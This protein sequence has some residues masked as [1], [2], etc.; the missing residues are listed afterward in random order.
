MGMQLHGA[1]VLLTGASG[2]FGQALALQLA[3]RGALLVLSG[4][5]QHALDHLAR[6]IQQQG[7]AAPEVLVA[8]LL[9][10]DDVRRLAQRCN[11]PTEPVDV[12]VLNA[13]VNRLGSFARSDGRALS[14]VLAVDLHAPMQLVHQCLPA[15]LR[16]PK[17][18]ILFVNST[19]GRLGHPGYAAYCAAKHGL[20]GLAEALR[21]ELSGSSVAVLEISPRAMHTPMNG[22]GAQALNESAGSSVDSPEA[23][24]A[25]AVRQLER[26]RARVFIGFAERFFIRLNQ[27]FP[28]LLD[29]VLGKRWPVLQAAAQRA[30]QHRTASIRP[31]RQES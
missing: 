8:D 24:A 28:S 18:S 23:V 12:L 29:R 26:G 16:R 13:G 2:G 30:E 20:K 5:R 6:Q 14:E 22:A 7:H 1:R 10:A 25:I 31:T 9:K 21:R 17:A 19:L 11:A 27:W 15:L 4:R 3:S